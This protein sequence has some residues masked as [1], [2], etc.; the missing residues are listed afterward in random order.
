MQRS[1]D[2]EDATGAWRESRAACES[3]DKLPR[4]A[5]ESRGNSET[6][7]NAPARSAGAPPRR[8]SRQPVRHDQTGWSAVG[9]R[10]SGA[11]KGQSPVVGL[12]APV[13]SIARPANNKLITEIEEAL[14]FTGYCAERSF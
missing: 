8:K 12:K 3:R 2:C 1:D 10:E 4:A 9:P 5:R 7:A 11:R 14:R 6:G 13:Q